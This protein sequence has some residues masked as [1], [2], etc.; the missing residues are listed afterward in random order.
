MVTITAVV[1]RSMT[2]HPT[3]ILLKRLP[4]ATLNYRIRTDTC[5]RFVFITTR[6]R[7]EDS[8][9]PWT[10]LSRN[11]ME[12]RL[13]LNRTPDALLTVRLTSIFLKNLPTVTPN[14][15]ISTDTRNLFVFMT[16]SVRA[17]DNMRRRTRLSRGLIVDTLDLTSTPHSMFTILQLMS[18]CP[19]NLLTVTL[20]YRISTDTRNLFA[21]M[22]T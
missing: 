18:I 1:R 13:Y 19:K 12:D 6:V 22:T 17:A 5:N 2:V 7:L 9:R 4:I 21:I 11:L 14:Y 20:N 3:S 15:R 10:R 8:M 16:T